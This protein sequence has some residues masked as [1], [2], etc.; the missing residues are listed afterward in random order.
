ML[1]RLFG[2][3]SKDIG[4]DLGTSNSIFYVKDRGIVI[5][6]PTVV[7]INTRTDALVAVGLDAKKMMGKTPSHIVVVEPVVAGVISDFEVSEKFIKHCIEKIHRGSFAFAP[8]PRIIVSVPLNITEVERKAVHDA[9]TSAGAREVRLIDEPIAAAIGARLSVQESYGRMVV[10][11]GG[12]TTSI[13]VI[14]LSGI[15]SSNTLKTAGNTFDIAIQTF[16]RENFNVNIGRKAAEE[17]KIKIGSVIP[18]EEPV[19]MQVKGRNMLTGLPKEF[20]ISDAQVR[21]AIKRPVRIIVDAIRTTVE[22]APSELIGDLFES[23]ILLSGGGALLKGFDTLIAKELSMPVRVVDDPLTAVV[24][25]TGI[26]LDDEALLNE[27]ESASPSF[28]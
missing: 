17:I 2:G 20:S 13:G 10:E 19:E 4:I 8:R 26:L 25:G 3:L 22:N 16:I 23:G 11:I 9:I 6:E 7:A 15:V 14:S 1:K 21:E 12:G 5:N 18:P 27:V 24:R 28:S